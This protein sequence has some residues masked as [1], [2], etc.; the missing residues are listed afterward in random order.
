MSLPE[1]S[2][3]KMP[4]AAKFHPKCRPIGSHRLRVATY[5]APS[6]GPA[7]SA[8]TAAPHRLASGFSRCHAPNSTLVGISAP[9]CRTAPPWS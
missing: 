5:A 2:V 4:E 1:T 6:T 8:M 3:L 7:D 9:M